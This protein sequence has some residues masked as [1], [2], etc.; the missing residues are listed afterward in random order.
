M[1]YAGIGTIFAELLYTYLRKLSL[2]YHSRS[3]Q[4][5]AY[6]SLHYAI[7]VSRGDE[8]GSESALS[9]MNCILVKHLANRIFS[10]LGHG[11]R[12]R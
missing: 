12:L 4:D 1:V 2:S 10:I 6:R 5:P 8:R 9:N 7:P 3:L 11:E